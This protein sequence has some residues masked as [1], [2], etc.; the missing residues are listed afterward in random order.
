[1]ID[2]I[3]PEQMK[4]QA[5]GLGRDGEIWGEMKQQAGGRGEMGRGG[6]R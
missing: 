6:E 5:G 2:N 3:S 4:Q 1:M